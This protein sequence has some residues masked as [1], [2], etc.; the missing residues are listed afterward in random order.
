M[1]SNRILWILACLFVLV[2]AAAAVASNR[3]SGAGLSPATGLEA[4]CSL[5]VQASGGGHGNGDDSDDDS[6]SDSGNGGHDGRKFYVCHIP[7]GNPGGAHT[8]QVGLPALCAHLAHGDTL[9]KCPEPCG[10]DAGDT[11]GDDA[12]CKKPMGACGDDAEG[13]CVDNPTV[14][15]TFIDPV[16]GCDGRTYSNACYAWVA[17]A[18]I[19]SRGACDDEVACGGAAGDTCGE[20]EFC[21]RSKGACGDDA[22]GV[23]MDTPPACPTVFAPVCGCDGQTYANECLADAAGVTVASAGECEVDVVC[24]GVAGDT[25]DEGEFCKRPVGACGDDAEGVCETIPATCPAI[26]ARVCGCDGTTYDNE[27]LADAAGATIASRGACDAAR[28][29]GGDA[30]DTCLEGEFCKRPVGACGDD[31]EGVCK[32][33]PLR[34][35]LV[36][37]PVCGCNGTTYVNACAADAEGVAVSATGPCQTSN[38]P[39]MRLGGG[40]SRRR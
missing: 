2:A 9:G 7:R 36:F 27:C 29:C 40:T 6:D 11:C 18:T 34:C 5:D 22:E 20:G 10:G 24:G 16:C 4:D 13:V 31:A 32:L 19:A 37:A 30:G 17:G 12:F 38:A 1:R 28:V 39:Q 35:P 14:C 26:L 25:C 23:C 3:S 33:Q 8:I 21:K 15:P